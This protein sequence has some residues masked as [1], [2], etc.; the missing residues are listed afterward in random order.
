MK[1]VAIVTTL[2]LVIIVAFLFVFFLISAN[3]PDD[4]FFNRNLRLKFD[5]SRTLREIL[6]LHYIGDARFDY[7][8]NSNSSI[9][10][11]VDQMEGLEI[12]QKALDLLAQKIQAI[13]G[14]PVDYFLSN[15]Y[16]PFQEQ[17]SDEEVQT[18]VKHY[19]GKGSKARAHLYLLYLN[20]YQ[21]ET[22]LLGS[23]YQEDTIILYGKDLKDF[24]KTSPDT[25]VNY[26]ESTALHEF[27]H[28]LG[29]E[30]ND[31]PG[32]LM[33]AR[34]E[35]GYYVQESASDV[36]VDFCPY[37]KEQIKIINDKF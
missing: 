7:L 10:I 30:H 25:F 34:A 5:R 17:V 6:G 28:Q 3:G 14:K 24:T 21:D 37:E 29:L 18:I 22:N 33:S 1:K 23:T 26:F 36:I 27:G 12:P 20:Q 4:N 11:E 19:E 9:L 13:T 15:P 35:H 16:I 8:G 31:E 2:L 32:C